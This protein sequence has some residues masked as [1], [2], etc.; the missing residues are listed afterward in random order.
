MSTIKK[1][2]VLFVCAGLVLLFPLQA[3]ASQT[4][5]SSS[6]YQ[7][8]IDDA[9]DL[10]SDTEEEEL[11]THMAPITEYGGVAF[12]SVSS[13]S[14]TALAYAESRYR[15]YFAQKSG[16]LFLIDM[17]NR[18]IALF[19]DG[20]VYRTVTKSYSNSIC[21]N[22]YTYASDSLYYECAAEAFDEVASLLEGGRI[23]QPM[24]YICNALLAVTAGMLITFALLLWS[25]R[26]EKP[27][28]AMAKPTI[29]ATVAGT[30]LLA[31]R[32]VHISSDSGSSGGGGGGGGGFSGGGRGGGGSSGGGGSHGF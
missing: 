31:S 14:S 10:L 9:A 6:G 24:K 7:M 1:V 17:D 20:A 18:E 23:S 3:L 8:Y 27:S 26:Q 5:S 12:V 28:M 30:V 11:L 19:C 32:R 4:A 15:Q 13:N 21:D 29:T 22:V 16:V 25:R 2:L